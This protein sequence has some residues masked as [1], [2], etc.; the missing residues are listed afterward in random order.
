MFWS[1]LWD[2]LWNKKPFLGA[3]PRS[4][5]WKK[6]RDGFI[7]KNP[8]CA[9]CG[10][11][12]GLECHHKTPYHIDPSK[13]L[14]EDNLITLCKMSGNCHYVW[15]HL[16]NWRAYN[17]TVTQDAKAFLEKINKRLTHDLESKK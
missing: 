2:S 16:L 14:D 10:G 17:P 4:G 8:T 15:G 12:E 6:V 1:N 7:K 3:P 9:A 11:T 5:S 13:E